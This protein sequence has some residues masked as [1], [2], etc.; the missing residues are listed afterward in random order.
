MLQIVWRSLSHRFL[1]VAER[2]GQRK[3]IL[4]GRGIHH[5]CAAM[6]LREIPGI[7]KPYTRAW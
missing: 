3:D 5:Q 7:C 2:Y 6:H 4:L 1:T